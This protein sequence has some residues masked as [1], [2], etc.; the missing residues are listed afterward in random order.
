MVLRDPPGNDTTVAET[1]TLCEAYFQIVFPSP[2]ADP[3][4]YGFIILNIRSVEVYGTR[5]GLFHTSI[6]AT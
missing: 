4:A 3:I 2:I 1:H 5:S 6:Q